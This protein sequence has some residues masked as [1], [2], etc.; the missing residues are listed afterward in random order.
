MF[1]SALT[2]LA[3]LAVSVWAW[4]FVEDLF[5]R[6]AILGA[7]GLVLAT[8]AGVAALALLAREIRT[9]T[10]QNRIAKLHIALAEA[11]AADELKGAR[12]RV[13]ELCKLYEHRPDTGRARAMIL[14]FSRQIIDGRDLID[15]AERN[16]I[17]PLDDLARREIATAA[18]R[19]SVVTTISPRALLDVLFVAGQAIVLMRK[20]A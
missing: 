18:K 2:G 16:L 17:A 10:R 12:A 6:S 7:V 19:V 14:E 1:W 8:A 15:L 5:H 4:N 11:H 13:T 20:I 3:S 9:M